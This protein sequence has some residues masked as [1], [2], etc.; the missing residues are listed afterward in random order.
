MMPS[1]LTIVHFLALGGHGVSC[2]L[3]QL[4]ISNSQRLGNINSLTLSSSQEYIVFHTSR[5]G[6]P[7]MV[8]FFSRGNGPG[9]PQ[10]SSSIFT[11]LFILSRHNSSRLG[12]WPSG[13]SLTHLGICA[14]VI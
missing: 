10:K 3:G 1:L 5:L 2:S 7:S 9:P 6:M 4:E 13:G 8:N 11:T 14:M 12:N